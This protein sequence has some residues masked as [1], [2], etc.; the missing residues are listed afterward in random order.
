MKRIRSIMAIISVLCVMGTFTLYTDKV[1]A[2]EA[3]TTEQ[4]TTQA[5]TEADGNTETTTESATKKKEAKSYSNGKQGLNKLKKKLKKQ[6]KG[7]HGKHCIYVKNLKTNEWMVINN[8]KMYPASTIKIFNMAAIYDQIGKKKM[9]ESSYIKGEMKSMI[10]VSSND[11][12]NNLLIKLGKGSPKKGVKV[13]NQF[14]KKNGYT[15]TTAGGTLTPCSTKNRCWIKKSRTTVRDLGHILEDIYRGQCVSK[16]ASKKM[17]SYLK[18]QQKRGKIPAG[19]PKGVK[20]ANKT[21]EAKSYE[22]DAAI[23]FS[24]KAD[25]VIVV[26]T[27][28]DGSAV[29]HIQSISRTVYKYFN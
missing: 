5:T 7:Y 12:F 6:I 2:T 3:S 19:L 27:D 28:G 1:H 14:C 20:S 13:L 10:T 17:L 8:R 9:K 23:V 15:K 21:G 22:H 18:K 4:T 24:K 26:M 11:A 29:S 16:K 25:Y